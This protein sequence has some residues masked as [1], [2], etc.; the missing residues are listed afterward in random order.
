MKDQHLFID[1]HVHFYGPEHVQAGLSAASRNFRSLASSAGLLVDYGLLLLADPKMAPGFSW[2]D[3]LSQR[4]SGDSLSETWQIVSKPDDDLLHL[5]KSNELPL[6][7]F[8]GRQLISAENL[9]VLI[10]PSAAAG[11]DGQPADQLVARA[12]ERDGLAILPWGV[13]KWLGQRGKTV[14]I[15]LDRNHSVP[16]TVGDN[17]GRP[18]IWRRVRILKDA[19]TAGLSDIAGTDPLPLPGEELRIGTFGVSSSSTVD[20]NW[21]AGDFVNLLRAGQFQRFGQLMPFKDFVAKQMALR[22][23]GKS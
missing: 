20:Q 15:I 18:R 14:S 5:A 2:V 7:I 13:G 11:E 12:A 4:H 17:G 22:M 9:E 3:R 16:I 1:G 23:V 6:A 19:R 10:F 21:T 8:G